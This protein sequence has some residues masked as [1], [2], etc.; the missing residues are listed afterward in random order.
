MKETQL[1][2]QQR[3]NFDE[4]QRDELTSYSAGY[5]EVPYYNTYASG[6]LGLKLT[7]RGADN[8]PTMG[9]RLALAI[10]SMV[11]LLLMLI[12][13][14]RLAFSGMSLSP[15]VARN[16][17]SVFVFTFLGFLVTMIVLNRVH[18]GGQRLAVAMASLVLLMLMFFA[19]VGLTFSGLIPGMVALPFAGFLALII[20]LNI[21]FNLRR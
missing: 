12:V 5:E 7:P 3:M 20:M 18:T 1:M 11:F 6:A 16:F 14:E 8:A 13:G 9:Q 2:S 19:G 21:V 10:V 15:D 17:I 4:N